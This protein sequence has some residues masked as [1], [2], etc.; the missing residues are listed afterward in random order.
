[1][2]IS[3]VFFLIASQVFVTSCSYVK[4]QFPDKEKDYQFSS[5]IPPI[6]L[7]DD[8]R[9]ND[10]ASELG[11]ATPKRP[12]TTDLQASDNNIE[13]A[14]QKQSELPDSDNEAAKEPSAAVTD[15][16]QE[17][18]TEE[19]KLIAVDLIKEDDDSH[20][21]IGAS[22]TRTWRIVDKALSRKS[23]EV[24]KRDQDGGLF[25]VKYDP[26]E[27][28]QK[29][30]SIWDEI[31]FMFTGFESEEQEYTLKLHSAGNATDVTVLDSSQQP[32]TD[33]YSLSLLNLL[34]ETIK[35]DLADAKV[36]N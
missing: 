9:V 31:V 17:A 5:E 27:R 34:H 36:S 28:N 18:I 26:K 11:A 12:V 4:S 25:I 23:V 13:E 10:V 22:S 3:T 21:H 24:T 30:G 35:T 8:L 7:P 16:S 6:T 1:M 32:V 33:E 2:K 15:T 29:D 20:L 19:S 14:K